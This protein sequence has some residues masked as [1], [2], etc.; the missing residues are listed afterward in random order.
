MFGLLALNVFGLIVGMVA[1]LLMPGCDP[2]GIIVTM[3]LG[4][5]GAILGGWIGRAMGLYRPEDPA[6]YCFLSRTVAQS[7]DA[8]PHQQYEVEVPPLSRMFALARLSCLIHEERAFDPHSFC[9]LSGIHAALKRN[10]CQPARAWRSLADLIT[11]KNFLKRP[12]EVKNA[13]PKSE[14]LAT[15]CPLKDVS[16]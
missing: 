3:S 12:G 13:L 16:A 11:L 1:K 10:S 14:T 6:G 5:V 2:G 4:I 7:A 9:A 8:Q 15:N